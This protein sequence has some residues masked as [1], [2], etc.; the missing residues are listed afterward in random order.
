MPRISYPAGSS[1]GG[2]GTPS[3]PPNSVQFNDAGAFG[4]SDLL[5]WNGSTLAF[6]T[7]KAGYV[8]KAF[9]DSG[10][11]VGG[12][13]ETVFWDCG[14]GSSI[15]SLPTAIGAGGR[16]ITVKR[17]DTSSNTLTVTSIGGTVE[18][19]ASYVVA[20]GGSRLSM[21]FRSDN[22]NWWIV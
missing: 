4:G 19:G 11:V 20:G 15:V 12:T 13:V 21:S 6:P 5:T 1:G 18:G 10:Y 16:T 2:G 14:A 3:A 8:S 9:L 17:T 22:T 7:S